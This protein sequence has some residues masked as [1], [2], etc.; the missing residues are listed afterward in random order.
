MTSDVA[1][2][3]PAPDITDPEL[4]PYW[5]GTAEGRLLVQ[6]CGTC[7]TRRWPPRPVCA[8]CGGLQT[9][10]IEVSGAGRVYSWT[11]V[12]RTRLDY[13]RAIVPYTVAIVELV[14]DPRLRMLGLLKLDS[15][16]SPSFGMDVRVTFHKVGDGVHLACWRASAGYLIPGSDGEHD[17]K[18]ARAGAD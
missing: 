16:D 14:D 2:E 4:A 18:H 11:E 9:E 13:F 7:E 3:W 1:P 10:W 5:Q 17:R 6:R 15:G 12:H 8:S